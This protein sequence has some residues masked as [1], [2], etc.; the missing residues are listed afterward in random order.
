MKKKQWK[1]Y[2]YCLLVSFIFLLL[3]SKCSP[4]YVINDWY[5]ANAFFTVGKS[6][7]RGTVPYLELFEQKG[8]LL[9]LIYGIGSIISPTTFFGVFLLEVISFS[10]FL[11]YISKIIELFLKEEMSYF[12]I[13]VL[14]FVIV[15]SRPFT[16]GG[17]AEEFIFPL[18]TASL[19]YLTKYLK[20][21]D[22]KIPRKEVLISGILAGAVLWIKYSLLGF[23]FGWMASVFFILLIKKEWKEAFLDCFIFLGGMII[24]SVPWVL[25][26]NMNGALEEMWN[27]YF[28]FNVSQYSSSISWYEKIFKT[29][30]VIFQVVTYYFQYLLLIFIPLLISIKEKTF[31]EEKKGSIVLLITAFLLLFGIFIGGVRFR[32]YSLPI[33]PFL[34]FGMIFFI[35]TCTMFENRNWKKE[36]RWIVTGIILACSLIF[37]CARSSNFAVITKGKDYYAQFRFASVIEKKEDAKIL[38]YGFLDGGFYLTSNTIPNVYYFERQ[39]ISHSVYPKNMDEQRK[40]IKNKEVDFIISKKQDEDLLKSMGSNYRLV[41]KH[42][43]IYEGKRVTYH[44]YQ[45]LES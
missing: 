3:C 41:K 33:A 13:P 16:H 19:Y 43:Q 18:L 31:Y 29:F 39:N 6:M 25:Y 38:N 2:G 35:K 44:L 21:K 26:F 37:T 5:D 1:K 8:P 36:E 11:Y 24:A 27:T 20:G 4:L 9:Y 28:L 42:Y 23:W 30:E 14:S 45:K 12:I 32:Y 7:V 17:S 22:A 15:C 10:I 34:V 40:Y